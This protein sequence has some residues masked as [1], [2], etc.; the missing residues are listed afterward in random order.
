MM[1]E[2]KRLR[3]EKLNQAMTMSDL[4]GVTR[5]DYCLL[6]RGSDSHCINL[7]NNVQKFLH[8]RGVTA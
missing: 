7:Y 2:V 4:S 6:I 8:L 1:I 3:W 5:P